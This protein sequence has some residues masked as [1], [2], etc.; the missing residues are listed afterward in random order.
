MSR[1]HHVVS[2]DFLSAFDH[3]H[4]SHLYNLPRFFS[5]FTNPAISRW[6]SV[7]LLC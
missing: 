1:Q 5:A 7:V 4:P 6:L 3:D 2:T